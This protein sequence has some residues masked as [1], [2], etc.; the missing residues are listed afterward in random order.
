LR[1]VAT[2]AGAEPG[3]LGALLDLHEAIDDPARS[4]ALDLHEANSH[5]GDP[6]AGKCQR[7]P[8]N[9]ALLRHSTGELLR[10]RCRATNLCRYCQ[11][12]YVVETVEM[13]TLDAVEHA[14]TLWIVLTAREHL[15]RSDCR[16]HLRQLL[17]A[18]RRRWPDVEWFVQVE[19]QRRGALHLNLLVKGVPVVD[20]DELHR[21]LV[22]RWC[23]RVDALPVGQWSGAI[24][25]GAGVVKYLAKMLAHGL[26]VEQRPP[27]GWRG[28][29]TSQTRGYLVRPASVMREEARESLRLK[30]KLWRGLSLEVA[31]FE[32]AQERDEVWSLR[33]VDPRGPAVRELD[34][35]RQCAAVGASER[36]ARPGHDLFHRSGAMATHCH[37]RADVNP[38]QRDESAGAAPGERSSS[39]VAPPSFRSGGSAR[40]SRGTRPPV[41]TALD[42]RAPPAAAAEGHA[43]P[44]WP[45]AS[46]PHQPL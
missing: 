38:A 32:L 42:G 9:F 17:Q 35:A 22:E 14:P 25:D 16:R 4:D 6:A 43:C 34:R 29:R 27:L 37:A 30:R 10:G 13:L 36:E 31:T 5:A 7:W 28:H 3:A 11:T 8:E 20:V 1:R 41:S 2:V 21:V 33:R 23:A 44:P 40:G 26:K 39:G 46:P 18:A 24:A 15:T 12:L 19:F 45:S